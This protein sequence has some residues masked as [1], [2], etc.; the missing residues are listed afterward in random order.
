M[1]CNALCREEITRQLP[2]SYGKSVVS[3]PKTERKYSNREKTKPNNYKYFNSHG[4]NQRNTNSS[5]WWSNKERDK[6][7]DEQSLRGHEN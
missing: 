1:C 7:V 3:Y 2:I 5:T 6:K 4:K